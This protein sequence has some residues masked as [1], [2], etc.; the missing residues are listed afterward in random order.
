MS[1]TVN[2]PGRAEASGPHPSAP[3][4]ARTRPMR[5]HVGP[6]LSYWPVLRWV[7]HVH[8][9]I[10]SR[11]GPEVA[12]QE[13][14]WARRLTSTYEENEQ[15][16]MVKV[17]HALHRETAALRDAFEQLP[18]QDQQIAAQEHRLETMSDREKPRRWSEAHLPEDITK[19]RRDRD[20]RQERRRLEEHVEALRASRAE[21]LG[22]C[23]R[24]HGVIVERYEIAVM[25][26]A[27]MRR[28]YSRRLG[29]YGRALSR[30]RSGVDGWDLSLPPVSHEIERC[31]WLPPGLDQRL[32]AGEREESGHAVS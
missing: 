22:R 20:A 30:R 25:I 7:D 11:R 17:R 23:A 3:R 2:R 32:S 16:L 5:R 19:V 31:P 12:P 26:S 9:W 21:S 27:Q 15:R 1:L 14:P 24:G 28:Y 18:A 29:T 4:R 6:A 8:G 13:L 10:D